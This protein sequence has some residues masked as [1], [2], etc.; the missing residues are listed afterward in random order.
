MMTS[1]PRA[2]SKRNAGGAGAIQDWVLP[3]IP[4]FQM[5]TPCARSGPW[6]GR[7]QYARSSQ[8]KRLPGCWL[9]ARASGWAAAGDA[10]RTAS[11]IA[12][13]AARQP[14]GIDVS[15]IGR[16]LWQVGRE[17][18]KDRVCQRPRAAVSSTAATPVARR[19]DTDGGHEPGK[20]RRSGRRRSWPR[21]PGDLRQRGH[22][23]AGAR[24][25]LRARLA[26]RGPREPDPTS[27]RFPGVL[28]GRGVG[29]PLP[30]PGRPGPRLPQLLPASR[31][32]G[33]P[34]RRGQH[35][36]VHVSLSR[37]ELCDRRRAG[38]GAVRQGRVRRAARPRPL[39]P[40]R[41]GAARE[42]QGHDLGDV[43]RGGAVVPRVP[44]RLQALPRPAPRRLGR[45][46][47][48]HRGHR[49]HPQVADPV[50]LEVSGRELLRRSLPRGEP[51]LGRHGR[52][53]AERQGPARHA[54]AQRGALARRVVPR[55]GPLDDRVP[56]PPRCAAGPGLP[57]RPDGRR[58]LPALRGGAAAPARRVLAALRRA[59]HRLSQRLAAGPA[60]ADARGVA[61]AR[62]A[63]DGGLALVPGR[64]RR[65]GGGQG[66]P[67]PLLHPLFGTVGADRAGRHGEL[68]LRPQGEPRHHR[69]PVSLQLR[70]GPAPRH[71][72][73]RGP[74]PGAAGLDRRRH[75]RQRER[76][77]PA[78]LLS[79]LAAVHGGA[80]LE[81][82]D[83]AVSV[84]SPELA[85]LLV[86]H[87]VEDFLYREAEL[88]D[89]RRYEEW[90]DLFTDDARYFMPMRRNVPHD[91]PAREFT[92]EGTDV[93]WFDEGKDTLARRVQQ[94]RTGIHWAEEPP[95]R[96]CH[97]VS[98]V[99]ILRATPAGPS[100]SEL[101]V[102]S[103]FLIYR[104]RVETETDVL[105]GKREDLLRR[106]N[107]AFKIARR[108]IVL[109]QS[110][111]LTKNLSFFF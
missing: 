70:D 28:D 80:E 34:V 2:W 10:P 97:M 78:R 86:R 110:V 53:R 96:I 56:A 101:A 11:A 49:R 55:A 50:Q 1:Q 54:G 71:P 27:R 33:L 47:G 13:T 94:L 26:L 95:S 92:R 57:G 83:G 99:E 25:R 35:G 74:R 60:A 106:Q 6:P 102:K 69:A 17:P 104:N 85:R 63:P 9:Q 111:L 40:R 90:L 76:E 12:R 43:G 100:P 42:L 46:R 29:D 38:R 73:L 22:L 15:S 32:E 58:L 14:R 39:G 64:R 4:W 67:A 41:G 88:L 20:S 79:P 19:R 109:D 36:R 44:R 23:P 108:K 16:R 91:Q 105:V 59:R 93:N 51:P 98:N 5:M 52:H 7:S 81:G 77:Q 3:E 48:G 31:D 21:Q 61:P 65:A 45:P 30:R 66:L 82:P 8:K 37:L 68:E 24:A 87:E 103:R 89:K 18:V 107:G 84:P 72:R 62:S 75:R